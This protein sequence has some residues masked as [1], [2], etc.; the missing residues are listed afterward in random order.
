MDDRLSGVSVRRAG[1]EEGE[2]EGVWEANGT[3]LDPDCSEG[4]VNLYT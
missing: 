3:V 1:L 2:Q 4:H